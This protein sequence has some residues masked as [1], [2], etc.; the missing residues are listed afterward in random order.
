MKNKKVSIEDFEIYHE[1]IGDCYIIGFSSYYTYKNKFCKIHD[2]FIIFN[3]EHINIIDR[4]N[5]RRDYQ[6][7][8]KNIVLKKLVDKYDDIL[9]IKKDDIPD[10]AKVQEFRPLVGIKANEKYYEQ[11]YKYIDPNYLEENN[12]K[13]EDKDKINEIADRLIFKDGKYGECPLDFDAMIYYIYYD[14][15]NEWLIPWNYSE[16][17]D[18]DEP[19]F[20]DLEI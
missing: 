14:E 12:I 11:Y 3:C 6:N 2:S 19:R 4:L 9:P 7:L 5:L 1:I 17:D 10:R 20:E 18:Y 8:F 13:W 16:T 15:N